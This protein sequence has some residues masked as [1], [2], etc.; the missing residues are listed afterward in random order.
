MAS[1]DLTSFTSYHYQE[2]DS[3]VILLDSDTE[4]DALIYGDT[5][6]YSP[7]GFARFKQFCEDNS[8]YY[9]ARTKKEFFI[10]EAVERAA[11]A[12]R[13]YLLWENLS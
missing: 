5:H 10:H 2:A 3:T 7:E 13:K 12:G 1:I 11:K 9:Y 6:P 4:L 8:V